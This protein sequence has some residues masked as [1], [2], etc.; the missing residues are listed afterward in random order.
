MLLEAYSLSEATEIGL[1]GIHFC[2]TK[3]KE[4]DNCRTW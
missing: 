1:F 2:K 4:I 3:N